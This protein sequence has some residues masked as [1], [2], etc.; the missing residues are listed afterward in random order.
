[1]V[2]W[3]LDNKKLNKYYFIKFS[4]CVFRLENL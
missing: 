4:Y 3:K 2:Y 1:M